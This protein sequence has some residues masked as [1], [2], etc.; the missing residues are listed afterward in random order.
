MSAGRP[1]KGTVRTVRRVRGAGMAK[2]KRPGITSAAL[3]VC[4]LACTACTFT[5]VALH[6][7]WNASQLGYQGELQG[8]RG[9]S[10]YG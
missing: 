4:C 10:S 2:G 9:G 3:G 8:L 6:M 7:L 5:H 1:M